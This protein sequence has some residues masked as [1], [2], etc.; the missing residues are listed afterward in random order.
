MPVNNWARIAQVRI[1]GSIHGQQTVNVMYFGTDLVANDAGELNA[2][3][4]A[5]AEAMRECILD[6]LLPAVTSDWRFVRVDAKE[7]F[8]T[9]TDP[10]VATGT[11]A[12]VGQLSPASAPFLASLV[13]IRSGFGGRRGRGRMFLPPPGETQT[14]SGLIDDP[15]L[16]LIAA[17]LAC[18]AAKFMGADPDSDW[19]LGV[20]SVKD[21]KAVGGSANGAFRLAASLNPNA[22]ISRMGSRAFGH[23]Q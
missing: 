20:F 18:V 7:I 14:T 21:F 10:V 2:I 4:V 13:N 11:P 1:I 19:H 16:V 6:F 12:N 5:L 22:A 17:F 8:P 3:L 9:Q 23:G 15:T